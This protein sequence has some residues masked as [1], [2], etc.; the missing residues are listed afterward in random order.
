MGRRADGEGAE[1]AG[2]S[3]SVMTERQ[4]NGLNLHRPEAWRAGLGADEE[5]LRLVS[6]VMKDR[7]HLLA[8]GVAPKL[9]KGMAPK[10]LQ[11]K[12]IGS[13]SGDAKRKPAAIVEI[14][15]ERLG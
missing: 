12:S 13:R 4:Q 7:A 10:L 9:E 8:I 3:Q 11:E 1:N 5:R 15:H 2:M 6:D 14:E